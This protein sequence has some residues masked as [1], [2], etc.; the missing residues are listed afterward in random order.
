MPQLCNSSW[1][2]SQS[3]TPF[4]RHGVYSRNYPPWYNPELHTAHDWETTV[5][6][7][8]MLNE[9]LV[10][11]DCMMYNVCVR[12]FC[13]WISKLQF[14][15]TWNWCM[16]CSQLGILVRKVISSWSVIHWNIE[17]EF[18]KFY[19]EICPIAVL[20]KWS[21]HGLLSN[22][23]MCVCVLF[24]TESVNCG[25]WLY[26]KLMHELFTVWDF[27]S[28]SYQFMVFYPLKHGVISIN[29]QNYQ[30]ICSF[31]VLEKLSVHGLLSIE[32]LSYLN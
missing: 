11:W 18:I 6:K 23:I 26:V 22:N 30:K 4:I 27:G 29:K 13:D 16:N 17:F 9:C 32:S 2:W 12:F 19:Q 20:Q 7:L 14:G 1:S 21:V 28:L 24:V 15:C 25:V 10:L 8:L 3:F 5:T 31:S